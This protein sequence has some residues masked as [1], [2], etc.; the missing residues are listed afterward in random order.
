MRMKITKTMKKMKTKAS[1]S[2]QM[3][4]RDYLVSF[5]WG[6]YNFTVNGVNNTSFYNDFRLI[7]NSKEKTVLAIRGNKE[8]EGSWAVVIEDN[9]MKFEL[10]FKNSEPFSLLNG[11]WILQE[12]DENMIHLKRESINKGSISIFKFERLT[13][14]SGICA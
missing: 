2:L 7:F 14:E 11:Q 12:C 6:I 8:V 5:T 4:L 9:N 1:V 10:D 13:H 3:I